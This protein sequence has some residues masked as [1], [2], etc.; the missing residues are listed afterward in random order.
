[1]LHRHRP[2]KVTELLTDFPPDV[3]HLGALLATHDGRCLVL[4]EPEVTSR[5]RCGGISVARTTLCDHANCPIH[6]NACSGDGG[7]SLGR[8]EV[9]TGA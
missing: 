7:G 2:G 8:V 3:R 4:D 9:S 5:Q 1:M 6:R